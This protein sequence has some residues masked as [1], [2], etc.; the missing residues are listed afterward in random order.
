MRRGSSDMNY[1][2]DL[3]FNNLQ[4]RYAITC[5]QFNSVVTQLRTKMGQFCLDLVIYSYFLI[6]IHRPVGEAQSMLIAFSLVC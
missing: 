1:K 5:K 2:Q 3:P 4:V 6:F